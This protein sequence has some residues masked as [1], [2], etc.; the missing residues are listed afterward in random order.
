MSMAT[1]A[2]PLIPSGVAVG[3]TAG[4]FGVLPSGSANYTIPIWT[5]PGIAGVSPS[6]ALSYSSSAGDGWYGVGWNLA[7]LSSIT[8]CAKTYG[9]D[10]LSANILLTIADLYCLDGKKLRSFAGTTYGADGA[11]YQTEVAD[12]SLV[13][14]NGTGVVRSPRQERAHLPVREHDGLGTPRDGNDNCVDVGIEPGERSVW[15]PLG[16]HV[17]Q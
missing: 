1:M 7:G 9:Q 6:L 5:P 14:W 16:R 13:I 10:G 15:Q 17:H 2:S 12:F 11:E 4:S 3:R 8:R